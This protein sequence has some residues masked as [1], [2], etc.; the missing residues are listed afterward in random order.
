MPSF[1][2]L[3][4]APTILAVPFLV[5][6]SL[7]AA[8]D[9]TPI[10]GETFAR[11]SV[12]VDPDGSGTILVPSP[13]AVVPET[14]RVAINVPEAEGILLLEKERILHHFPLPSGSTPVHD[15]AA[16]GRLLVAGRHAGEGLS[17][18]DLQIFDLRTGLSIASVQSNN[19]HLRVDPGAGEQW[20]VVI[21][22][23]RVGVFHPPTAASYPLWIREEGVLP[24]PVQMARA[25]AG[26]GFGSGA[27]WTPE[28]DGSVSARTRGATVT[29][30]D[31]GLGEFLDPVLDRAVLLGQPVATVRA[32]ADGET[33]LP[34]EIG[35]RLVDV[36]GKRTDFRLQT[37]AADVKARRLVIQ[38]RPVRVV[39][40]RIYW[41]YLGRDYLEIR[42]VPASEIPGT[43]L[44]PAPSSRGD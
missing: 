16:A 33:L 43:P 25:S 40:D 22:G 28:P 26:I 23:T 35:V 11:V 24:G 30:A 5:L 6:P 44:A 17:T 42:T 13:F 14:G 27:A 8:D 38:G 3:V 9:T 32:D 18:V 1:V 19:P 15:L 37:M 7:A 41:M 39:G 12:T 36:A 34:H 29:F 31:P 10:H 2:S 20:R 21:D 4:R